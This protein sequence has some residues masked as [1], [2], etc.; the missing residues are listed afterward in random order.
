MTGKTCWETFKV[1]GAN[2]VDR[3][4]NLIHEGNVRRVIVEHKGK[5]IAEFPLTVGVVGAVIAPVAAIV[6]VLIAM[7]QDCTI[8][9]ERE[10]SAS[11]ESPST[12]PEVIEVK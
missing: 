11:D 6:G 2:V 1:E 7:L 5:T 8:K 9:V 10:V 12:A 4:N 3:L